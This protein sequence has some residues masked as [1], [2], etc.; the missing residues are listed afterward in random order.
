MGP[1]HSAAKAAPAGDDGFG[2]RLAFRLR[3][4][5]IPPKSSLFA[6]ALAL[7]VA[8]ASA[9]SADE[10]LWTFDNFPAAKVKAAYG[11][12]I[13]PAWLDHVRAA[14]V[15][16]SVGCSGSVVSPGGLVLSNNHCVAGCAHDLSPPGGDFFKTGYLAATAPEEK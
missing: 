10:G 5:M 8:C 4:A 1:P 3:S 16:L 7:A 11:V 9:A 6:A 2:W 13:T 14:S 12:E 15:R